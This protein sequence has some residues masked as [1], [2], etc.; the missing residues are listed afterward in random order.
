MIINNTKDERRQSMHAATMGLR[1]KLRTPK[2]MVLILI[3]L[4][5]ILL[6]KEKFYPAVPESSGYDNAVM[7]SMIHQKRT[8]FIQQARELA[9]QSNDSVRYFRNLKQC[10]AW[11]VQKLSSDNVANIDDL[12]VLAIWGLLYKTARCDHD[13]RLMDSVAEREQSIGGELVLPNLQQVILNDLGLM[14]G[15]GLQ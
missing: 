2:G 5:G 4:A 3:I 7:R 6:V 12:K 8:T 14:V 9:L 13:W 15:T 1:S 10:R 11:I